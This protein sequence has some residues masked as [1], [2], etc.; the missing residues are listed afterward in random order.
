M[1]LS[2]T[3]LPGGQKPPLRRWEASAHLKSTH[4]LNVAHA[5]LAKY[6]TKGGGP[7]YYSAR[8]PGSKRGTPLYPVEQLD[9]WARERL[10]RLCRNTSDTVGI[11]E[12]EE[13][14]PTA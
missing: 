11:A 3:P 4:G 2:T 12:T 13:D 1:A 5:T 7:L 14:E 10:G 9:I 8:S 6:A